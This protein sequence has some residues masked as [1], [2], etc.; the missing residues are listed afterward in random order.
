MLDA[1]DASQADR[2][3][4]DGQPSG[5]GGKPCPGGGFPGTKRF[6]TFGPFTNNSAA[7]ACFTVAIDATVPG[8]AGA[9]IES[10]AYLGSYDPTNLC[11]N[12]LGDTGVVG[13][14]TTLG[15]A[16]YSFTVAAGAQFVVV[17]NTTGTV[18]T[19]S[20]FSGT[21]SGFVDD[22]PGNGPCPA[23]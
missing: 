7:A 13:L 17:V 5:C 6:Q 20:Q 21:I 22:T 1:N 9:D 3:G 10:A 8:P 15:N 23:R 4:R 12:Y 19:T 11:L 2:L 18:P 16:S 14:G